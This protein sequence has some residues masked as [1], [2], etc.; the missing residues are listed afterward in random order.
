MT[1]VQI[2]PPPK[3]V[4]AQRARLWSQE[5]PIAAV[6]HDLETDNWHQTDR[7]SDARKTQISRSASSRG[8]GP[9]PIRSPAWSNPTCSPGRSD[10]LHG[11]APEST[12]GKEDALS[13][14]PP[15]GRRPQSC[16]RTGSLSGFLTWTMAQEL[17]L[18][19]QVVSLFGDKLE[20]AVNA[21]VKKGY[22]VVVLKKGTRAAMPWSQ[23]ETGQD[24]VPL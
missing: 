1:H 8:R 3:R 17:D 22:E 5:T 10:R 20:D 7:R 13:E 6:L 19:S 23:Q 15:A 4:R 16:S 24:W 12:G 9:V 2:L 21:L 11:S 14:G 18:R